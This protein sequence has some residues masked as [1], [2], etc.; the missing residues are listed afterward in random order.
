M[1]LGQTLLRRYCSIG[2]LGR[3]LLVTLLAAASNFGIIFVQ[4]MKAARASGTHVIDGFAITI[5]YFGPPVGFYARFFAFA[6]LL[7]AAVGVFRRAFPR[8]I[9]ATLGVAAALLAYIYWWRDSYRVFRNFTDAD[10]QFLN[11]P[12]VKQV[13][14]LYNG[15][16]FDVSVAVSIVVCFVLLLDRLLNRNWR[17]RAA[18]HA[19]QL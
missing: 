18:F 1:S 15:S 5:C 17:A 19:N 6:G 4:N 7:L 3:F 10:I 8:S 16:W 9:L 12:E 14:Y 13:L 2:W 11:N